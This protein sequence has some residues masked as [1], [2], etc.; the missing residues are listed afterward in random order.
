MITVKDILNF[1]DQEGISYKFE[2]MEDLI[3]DGF[4][5]PSELKDNSII[6]IKEPSKFEK[7]HRT[8]KNVFVI[9]DERFVSDENLTILY[10]SNSKAVFF[11]VLSHFFGSK[12]HR[13]GIERSAVV[14]TK[15]IGH[16]VYIGHQ[17]FVDEDVLIGNN[18]VIKHHVVLE[19]KVVIG[20]NTVISSGVVIGSDGFGYYNEAQR[21]NLKVEHFGGVVIGS[22]VEIGA[23]TCIDRG[24]LGDTVIGNNV[25]IDNLCHIAHNVQIKDSVNIIALS[26]IGGSVRL[27]DSAYIAPSS[28]LINQVTVGDHAMI[29]IGSL[30]LENVEDDTVVVG[31]PA[32]VL[33]KR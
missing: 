33:R 24:T 14:L 4:S 17:S 15:N 12:V 16:D 11:S 2:G 21:K 10:S 23:N 1:V 30:V 29:G 9:T 22:D 6:W 3:I 20:D 27:G 19:G 5:R 7:D 31:H 28:T 18:V 13:T 32:Q 26:M 8:L 25:K